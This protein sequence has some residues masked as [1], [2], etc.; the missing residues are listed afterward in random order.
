MPHPR[1]PPLPR[2]RGPAGPVG[3]WAPASSKCSGESE[4]TVPTT[5]VWPER[6]TRES[7]WVTRFLLS[8]ASRDA[9]AP[10]GKGAA[11]TAPVSS[12]ARPYSHLLPVRM[13]SRPHNHHIDILCSPANLP[14]APARV[15]STQPCRPCSRYADLVNPMLSRMTAPGP[16]GSGSGSARLSRSKASFFVH[17]FRRKSAT[18]WVVSCSPG[19][20]RYPKPKGA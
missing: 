9:V 11:A 20:R 2:C 19:Q 4:A 1:G 14:S 18:T 13:A 10:G 16:M 8:S 12:R 7:L 15:R 17:T 3:L 5:T 6:L